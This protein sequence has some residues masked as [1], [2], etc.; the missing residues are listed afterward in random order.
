MYISINAL[1]NN[2]KKDIVFILIGIFLS[3][4]P[5]SGE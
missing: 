1:K 5:G 3:E 4:Q 2:A